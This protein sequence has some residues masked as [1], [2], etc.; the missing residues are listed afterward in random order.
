[1]CLR[2]GCRNDTQRRHCC[3]H[4]AHQSPSHLLNASARRKL[5]HGLYLARLTTR[6]PQRTLANSSVASQRRAWRARGRRQ[7]VGSRAHRN[8][9]D[10]R[11][12]VPG[13]AH[14]ARPRHVAGIRTSGYRA[15][16][17]SVFYSVWRSSRHVVAGNARQLRRADQ[18]TRPRSR[19]GGCPIRRRQPTSA[20][21]R[22]STR[23]RS[24][25]HY[26]DLE[27]GVVRTSC[28]A[29]AHAGDG[30]AA[31][32]RRSTRA[33]FARRSRITDGKRDIRRAAPRAARSDGSGGHRNGR[34]S[35]RARSSSAAGACAR[36]AATT[37]TPTGGAGAAAFSSSADSAPRADA[38]A[39]ADA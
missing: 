1:M 35:A 31:R 23:G 5:L 39:A 25:V 6:E 17:R 38:A 13:G 3:S 2:G 14:V 33:A 28:V 10:Y 16:F 18:A 30:R 4:R 27:H 37:G 36:A 9:A 26:S 12:G 22:G 20:P 11:S 34:R 19:G 7:D 32:R 21:R 8:G 15:A 24:S 29:G